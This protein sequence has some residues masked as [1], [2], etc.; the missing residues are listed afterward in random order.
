[1]NGTDTVESRSDRRQRYS[2]VPHYPGRVRGDLRQSNQVHPPARQIAALPDH[3]EPTS[4]GAAAA[5]RSKTERHLEDRRLPQGG[6]A[7]NF[8]ASR[9]S[10]A[11]TLGVNDKKK[12]GFLAVLGLVVVY[13]FYTNVLAGPD[14]PSSS[15]PTPRNTAAAPAP[16][17]AQP[18]G[19]PSA[20]RGTTARSR[21]EEFR[22]AL[23]S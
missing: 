14:V 4:R 23:R 16:A 3:R 18:A 22:P 9:R 15:A 11:M 19:P 7:G 17:A 1:R 20:P 6:R 5:G 13:L 21:S 2:D 8:V 12:V 10:P